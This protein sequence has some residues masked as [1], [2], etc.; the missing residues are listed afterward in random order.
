MEGRDRF[1]RHYSLLPCEYRTGLSGRGAL[2]MD[3]S[4][5]ARWDGALRGASHAYLVCARLLASRSAADAEN[6][7]LR[8]DDVGAVD[9]A[10]VDSS[11]EEPSEVGVIRWWCRVSSGNHCNDDDPICEPGLHRCGSDHFSSRD[12]VVARCFG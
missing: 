7:K 9:S 10:D 4:N 8:R 5:V 2:E 3:E 1:G 12:N 6:R 11:R